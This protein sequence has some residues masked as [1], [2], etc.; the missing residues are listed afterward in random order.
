MA[1]ATVAAAT[2]HKDEV[3]AEAS[4]PKDAEGNPK[5]D[6]APEVKAP[7]EKEV[8]AAVDVNVTAQD[9]PLNTSEDAVTAFLRGQ[10]NEDILRRVVSKYG[11]VSYHWLTKDQLASYSVKVPEDLVFDS[12]SPPTTWKEREEIVEAK[13]QERKAAME[14]TLESLDESD[15]RDVAAEKRAL[16]H[17]LETLYPEDNKKTKTTEKK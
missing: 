16:K 2:Q 12:P 4:A 1:T 14:E 15:S 3:I 8:E 7:T 17:D 5:K 11:K 9:I 6:D 10:I 13:R